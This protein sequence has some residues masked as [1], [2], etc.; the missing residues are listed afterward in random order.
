M[1]T[2]SEPALG[3][4]AAAEVRC[5]AYTEVS[6]SSGGLHGPQPP[7]PGF[8]QGS[9]EEQAKRDQ[10]AREQATREGE[11][12][13]RAE[14]QAEL[15]QVRESVCAALANFSKERA[16][17]YQQVETE[18]VKLA[19]SIARKILHREAQLDPLLLASLV[20]VALQQI[21]SGTQ[22]VLRVHPQ[23][24]SEFRSFFAQHMDTQNVPE[25]AEDPAVGKEGCVLHTSLGTTEL[26]IEVQLKEIEQGLFDLLAQ[27]P[28]GAQ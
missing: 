22:V 10:A 11:S 28:P 27:R 26:G 4:P 12:R 24:V 14:C 5:F 15:N 18:V 3:V 23:Q 19:L 2:S 9:S 20:H 17:Y 21:E 13:A 6:V 1:S 8:P 16:A 7:S 25:V